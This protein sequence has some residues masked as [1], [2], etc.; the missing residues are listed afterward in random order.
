MPPWNR[1]RFPFQEPPTLSHGPNGGRN[2]RQVTVGQDSE[3]SHAI[4]F[5]PLTHSPHTACRDR[6]FAGKQFA[7][8][9]IPSTPQSS[10]HAVP[11][12]LI[13]HSPTHPLSSSPTHLFTPSPRDPVAEYRTSGHQIGLQS[14]NGATDE[15]EM[16]HFGFMKGTNASHEV[17]IAGGDHAVEHVIDL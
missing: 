16:A 1:S 5:C 15:L 17:R 12:L 13:T 10:Q 8:N 14:F 2:V 4:A 11:H 6:R 9:G 3:T 7:G